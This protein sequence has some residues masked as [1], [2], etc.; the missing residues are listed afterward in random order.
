MPDLG[1]IA[2]RSR[3][4]GLELSS[5]TVEE[6]NLVLERFAEEIY[7]NRNEILEANK[8]DMENSERN[9]VSESMRMRLLMDEPKLRACISSVRDVMNLEDPLGKCS[10]AREITSNGLKL[11]RRTCPIGVILVIFEARPEVA[12]QISSLT[13]KSGNAVILKGGKEALNTNKA[14][15]N[16]VHNAINRVKKN[17]VN[18]KE[19]IVQMIFSHQDVKELLSLNQFIDL[20]IPRGSGKLVHMI[21]ENTCIPVLGH[22]D[23]VCMLYVH[24]DAN[25]SE[26]VDIVVDSKLDYPAACNSL[27]TL[28]VHRDKLSEFLPALLSRLREQRREIRFYLDRECFGYMADWG[29]VR[30]LTEDLYHHEFSS[31]EMCVKSVSGL[32]EAVSHINRY[33]SHHTDVILTQDSDTAASFMSRVDS[34]CVFHNCSSRFSDGYRFGFGAE[35]GIS[36]TR[37]HAR[38]PVGLEGLLTYKYLLKGQGQTLAQ[39]KNGEFTFTRR[40][41]G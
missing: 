14:I 9:G 15:L 2:R 6:R 12:I 30:E 11:F 26:G 39:F 7:L 27:E 24:V 23:G 3:E 13:I 20:V 25:I 4:S 5:S 35:V 37:I 31:N 28:L 8:L 18:I 32:D 29:D 10:L 1:E 33:G 22:A 40:E 16:C 19:E 34:A 36:T 38:G 41:I 21:Q 17:Y